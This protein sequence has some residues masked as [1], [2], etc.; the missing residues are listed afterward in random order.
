MVSWS[1]IPNVRIRIKKLPAKRV[2]MLRSLWKCG[3]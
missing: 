3:R 1:A 2:R